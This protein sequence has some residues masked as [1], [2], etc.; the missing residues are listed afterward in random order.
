M[1]LFATLELSLRVLLHTATLKN[2]NNNNEKIEDLL[3]RT[4][5]CTSD[6][7]AQPITG[8][9]FIQ[10]TSPT[11]VCHPLSVTIVYI[12]QADQVNFSS[13]SVS[14]V[15]ITEAYF[16]SFHPYPFLFFYN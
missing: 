9:K 16:S 8:Q 7:Q 10:S 2:I 11:L 15:Y 4:L 3:A 5:Y 6:S 12:T 13:M 1:P 14:I